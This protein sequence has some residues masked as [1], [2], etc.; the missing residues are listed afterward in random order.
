[1]SALIASAGIFSGH[2]A[3][4]LFIW[5][6]AFSISALLGL[7]Q[8]IWS[9]SSAG[10]MSGGFWGGDR[11]SSYSKCSLHLFNWPSSL[12]STLPFLSLMGL[13]VRLY[14]P[15]NFLVISVVSCFLELVHPL[16]P[17]LGLQWSLP[18][19]FLR[20]SWLLCLPLCT[21]PVLLLLLLSFGCC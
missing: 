17:W 11:F 13:S 14:F 6:M 10:V 21:L 8:F 4:P 3:F 2:E 15:A 12:V 1:M 18:C 20:C 9:T 7:S 5:W 16:L 19:L